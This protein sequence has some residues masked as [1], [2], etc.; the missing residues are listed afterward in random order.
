MLFVL[1]LGIGGVS[2]NLLIDPGEND[3]KENGREQDQ[4]D[5]DQSNGAQ[6][7]QD[8]TGKSQS[9]W[10]RLLILLLQSLI[11]VAFLFLSLV[12]VP[13]AGAVGWVAV[14]FSSVA[15]IFAMGYCAYCT[16]KWLRCHCERVVAH[17][18]GKTMS[19]QQSGEDDMER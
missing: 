14:A 1:A 5:Q 18:Q 2:I 7:K 12:T 3:T 8:H 13:Y 16:N 19:Q 4:T 9:V 17:F 10:L 6:A 15:E 11:I